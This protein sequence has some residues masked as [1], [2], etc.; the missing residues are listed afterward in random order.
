MGQVDSKING[1][2]SQMIVVRDFKQQ[3]Q[4]IMKYIDAQI[5]RLFGFCTITLKISKIYPTKIYKISNMH[6]FALYGDGSPYIPFYCLN[7]HLLKIKLCF[8]DN[9]FFWSL[10]SLKSD[11]WNTFGHSAIHRREALFPGPTSKVEYR[12]RQ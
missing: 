3:Y 6:R 1:K 11:P 12:S 7:I 10:T 2:L 8:T 4:L 5:I 9:K